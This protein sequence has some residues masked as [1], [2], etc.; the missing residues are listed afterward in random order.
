MIYKLYPISR[1][2]SDSTVKALNFISFLT[3]FFFQFVIGSSDVPVIKR[4]G[5]VHKCEKRLIQ[6]YIKMHVFTDPAGQYPAD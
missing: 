6:T 1:V 3:F 4:S 5:C 2:N